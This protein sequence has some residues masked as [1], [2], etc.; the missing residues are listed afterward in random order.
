MACGLL[1]NHSSSA[2]ISLEENGRLARRSQWG[3]ASAV[4]SIAVVVGSVMDGARSS[5]VVYCS[6]VRHGGATLLHRSNFVRAPVHRVSSF[7]RI[8]G[9]SWMSTRLG[10]PDGFGLGREQTFRVVISVRGRTSLLFELL[11]IRTSAICVV[12]IF[13]SFRGVLGLE[14]EALCR[15]CTPACAVSPGGAPGRRGYC[16]AGH[17]RPRRSRRGRCR[18]NRAMR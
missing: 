11:P 12:F 10:F 1:S 7:R 8:C 9:G 4:G 18:S 6:L 3:R 15:H 16:R 14:N 2:A 17:R 13:V 5:L